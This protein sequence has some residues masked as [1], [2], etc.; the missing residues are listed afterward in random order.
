MACSCETVSSGS[1]GGVVSSGSSATWGV[2]GSDLVVV[3]SGCA[4]GVSV[5]DAQP[6]MRTA[7]SV[8]MPTAIFRLVP[9]VV[10][11]VVRAGSFSARA[12]FTARTGTVPGFALPH[13]PDARLEP[14]VDRRGCLVGL[15]GQLPAG[16]GAEV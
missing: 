13:L 5:D 8:A 4:S 10:P 14:P 12:P 1:G 3:V 15:V 9:I 16:R 6:A 11:S 7:V 2:A